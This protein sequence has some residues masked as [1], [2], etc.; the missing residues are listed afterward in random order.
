M[1]CLQLGNNFGKKTFTIQLSEDIFAVLRKYRKIRDETG[2]ETVPEGSTPPAGAGPTLA[3]RAGGVGPSE[4]VSYQAS[5]PYLPF[6]TKL[7][8]I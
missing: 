2:Q 4:S 7:H 1:A 3:V 8:N 6:V 5:S